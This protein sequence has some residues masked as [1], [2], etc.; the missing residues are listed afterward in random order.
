MLHHPKN[1]RTLTANTISAQVEAGDVASTIGATS[2]RVK[3]FTSAPVA[4]GTVGAQPEFCR[5]KDS[6][7]VFSVSRSYLYGLIREGRVRSFVLRN[8][9]RKSGIRMVDVASV[10]AFLRSEQEKAGDA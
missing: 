2:H 7:A 8:R 9:G 6:R 3:Q 5:P 10:N 1:T 4:S